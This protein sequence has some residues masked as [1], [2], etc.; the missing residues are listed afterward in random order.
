MVLTALVQA[1]L[2]GI[3]LWFCG[4]PHPGLLTA[5]AFILGIAQIGPVLVLAP[6]VFWLYWTGS[7]GWATAL[8]VWSLPVRCSTTSCGR[9]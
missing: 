6:A 5:I 1:L 8:L 7:T 4:I 2:A 3:G 9:S